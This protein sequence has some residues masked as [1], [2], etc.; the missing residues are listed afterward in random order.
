MALISDDDEFFRTAINKMLID[1]LGFTS[2]TE[3]TSFDEALDCLNGDESYSLALFDLSMPGI[4]SPAALRTIRETFDVDRIAVVSGSRRRSDIL[5]SLEAGVHGYIPKWL[6]VRELRHALQIVVDGTI[7][8]PASLADLDTNE[9]RTKA[10]SPERQSASNAPPLTPRQ[11]EVLTMLVE[12]KSTK[13]IARALDLGMGT[14]KV[15]LAALFRTLGVAN[16]SAAAVAGVR[17]LERL[18]EEAE[19]GKSNR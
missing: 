9:A 16:R 17:L 15:H 14:V 10:A 19:S 8:V 18:Y 6:G 11:R 7:Y 2:V 13:E 12:G 1:D 4:D 3:A 5:M